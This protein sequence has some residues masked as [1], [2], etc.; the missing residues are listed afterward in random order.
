MK[1]LLSLLLFSGVSLT[2]LAQN[3]IIRDQFT[4]DPTARVFNNKV[5]LFPSH[6]IKPPVGQRQ[7]WFCMEDYHVFSS[8]NLTDW[9]DHGCGRPTVS[10]RMEST[11]STSPQLLR[12][13]E[14]VLVWV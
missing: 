2:A 14:A 12:R 7:D 13:A 3:P 5:Y 11:I 9:T 6:D 4:A 1:Y 10:R 8:E